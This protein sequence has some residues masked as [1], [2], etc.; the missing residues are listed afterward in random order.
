M[1]TSLH[2]VS[3]LDALMRTWDWRLDNQSLAHGTPSFALESF[4]STCSNGSLRNM[5]VNHTSLYTSLPELVCCVEPDRVG[6]QA[7]IEIFSRPSQP[8]ESAIL[9]HIPMR[10]H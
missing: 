9:T 1:T 5:T 8:L 2:D 7:T 6:L 10:S 3:T 4:S